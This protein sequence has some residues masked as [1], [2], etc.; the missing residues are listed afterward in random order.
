MRELLF[1]VP[2][3]VLCAGV[4]PAQAPPEWHDELADHLAGVWKLEG[5]VLG[6]EAHHEL[7]AEWVL[8]HQFLVLHEKTAAGAPKTKS[9]YEAVWYFG[10]DAVSERYVLHLMDVF[11]ARFS[12]TLGYG[13]RDGNRI[14]FTFEYPDGPFHNT[15]VW[16]PETGTWE[17][18]ME[19]KDKNG[20][21]TP[22]AE[23][24][25]TRVA[26]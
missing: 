5:Q 16:H 22:F 18:R 17:W 24:K 15:Y 6:R 14:R 23:F 19:Q 8:N 3:V 12:E 25:L 10:Y 13:V 20:K 26:G 2:A 11:G 7:R 9:R 1:A 4:V 21:W